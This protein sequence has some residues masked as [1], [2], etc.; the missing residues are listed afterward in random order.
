MNSGPYSVGTDGSNDEAGLKKLNPI[1]IHRFNNAKGT[2]SSQL[3]DMGANKESTAEALFNNIDRVFQENQ[4]SWQNCV[5]LSV[6]NT[7]V[8]VGKRNSIK[9]RVL[10]TNPN[11]FVNGCPC[12]I[13]HNTVCKAAEMFSTV[14]GFDVEDFLVDLFHWFDKSS[15]RKV[16]IHKLNSFLIKTLLN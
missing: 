4:I 9:S 3:L 10:K 11:I 12:H 7:V 5:A 1:L 6:D 8:N 14:S 16:S 15:K 13:I 2:V